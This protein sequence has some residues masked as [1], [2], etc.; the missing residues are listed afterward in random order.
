MTRPVVVLGA[1]GSI[2][3]QTLEV[4]DNLGF[5]VVGLAARDPSPGLEKLAAR[6]PSA[7]IAVAGGSAEDR[8]SFE[9][10]VSRPVTYDTDSVIDLARI[11]GAIVV[12]GIVGAAGLRATVA[13]LEAGNR[14][15]LANKESLVAGGPVV[16][17]ALSEHGG[18]LIPVDSE[19][20]ALMQ[21]LVGESPDS[22][23][24]L[25][26]TASGGPFRGRDRDSLAEVTPEEALRHPTWEMGRRITIDSATL[27]NK[28]LEV[29][30][31]HYLF[32]IP[33][34][35]IDVVVH[36]QSILHSAVEFV[37]G[38]WK[39]HFG[40]PDMR[41]PIQYALT[42]PE[43]ARAP[44]QPFSFSDLSLTFEEL[45]RITFPAV[46]LAFAAGAQGGSSP[47]V[48]NA[49]DEVAVEAFLQGRLGF[50]GITEV[51]ARTMEMVPW[52]EVIDVETVLAVDAEARATAAAL[53][54][55]AC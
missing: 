4:A 55:G 14:V 9:I 21:C 1:T 39:G 13:A 30:E 36:P 27:F 10:R 3:S 43:R 52:R 28:G 18:E 47:A 23:A 12:N 53:I 22:V 37:D 8:K 50:L 32:D 41:I 45:D 5:E 51:V 49:A 11:P 24:R 40:R 26:L 46:D 7:R 29:I 34:E 35:A 44:V 19:H 48:L 17:A 2:G 20:S 15:A 16:K 38:S 42:A 25:M 6:Y 54:A 31:A 33:F